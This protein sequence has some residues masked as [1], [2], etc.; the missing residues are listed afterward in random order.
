MAKKKIKDEEIF[1]IVDEDGYELEQFL[2]RCP[3]KGATLS[4]TSP[5]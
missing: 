1:E 4:E 2:C 3:S 5:S